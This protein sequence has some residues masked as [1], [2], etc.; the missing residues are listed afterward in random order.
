MKKLATI[1]TLVMALIAGGAVADAKTHSRTKTRSSSSSSRNK[2][3][4]PSGLRFTISNQ[5]KFTPCSKY[6]ID[7]E[8]LPVEDVYTFE[9]V[10]S[11]TNPDENYEAGSFSYIISIPKNFP[12]D[13]VKNIVLNKANE[14]CERLFNVEYY[15]KNGDEEEYKKLVNSS[16]YSFNSTETFIQKWEQIFNILSQKYSIKKNN[17]SNT[18]FFLHEI[19]CN[20]IYEDSKYVTY[21]FLNLSEDSITGGVFYDSEYVTYDKSTGKILKFSDINFTNGKEVL[22]QK[23]QAVYKAH[24]KAADLTPER[25]SSNTW[26]KEL[27]GVALVNEGLMF[28]YPTYM[29]G[30]KYMGSNL[31]IPGKLS[32]K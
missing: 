31:I 9:D 28:C 7:E 21:V 2:S 11:L 6:Y 19:I 3:G 8:N 22:K 16:E 13:V 4:T 32:V 18:E 5:V 25:I 29:L 20:Q 12:S 30:P 24:A 27:L 17:Y 23:L 26:F 15:V 10:F 14:V 1:I